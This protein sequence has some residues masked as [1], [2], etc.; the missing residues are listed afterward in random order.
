MTHQIIAI[1]CSTC[2]SDDVSRDA[3]AQWDIDIQEWT[4]RHVYDAGYCHRCDCEAH[5][6]ELPLKK[7][8]RVIE[9]A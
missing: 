4:L 8:A 9:S 3:W 5:L 1:V 7:R 2:G 6:E